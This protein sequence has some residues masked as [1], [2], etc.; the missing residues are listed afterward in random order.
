MAENQHQLDTTTDLTTEAVEQYLHT[1]IPLSRHI[2]IRVGS[3][4]NGVKLYAPIEPNLNHEATAFGGSISAVAMLAGW[5][6]LYVR[7]RSLTEPRRI[8]IQRSEAQFLAPIETEFCASCGPPPSGEWRRFI[9][10][11]NR[12]GKSRI[13]IRCIVSAQGSQAAVFDGTYV[14]MK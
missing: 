14:A 8:V 11:L 4:T 12:R 5:T 2:G 1:H 10:L 13:T 7:L 6:Y 3:L 9:E